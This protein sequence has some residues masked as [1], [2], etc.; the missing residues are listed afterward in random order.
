[1]LVLIL[2]L[3]ATIILHVLYTKMVKS[4]SEY[5]EIQINSLMWLRNS[6][7]ALSILSLFFLSYTTVPAGHVKVATLFGKIQ[8]KPYAEGLHFPVNPLLDWTTFDLRQKT[9]KETAG[10]PSQDKL[11]TD[12][13]VSVQY[14]TIGSK[15]TEILK[16]T[17]QIED[18][19]DVHLIPKLRSILREQGKGVK[20]AQDFFLESV[21][22]QLQISLQEELASYLAPQGLQIDSV[23]IRSVV[24]PHVIRSAIEQ[25]K[26]REQEV[27]K[28]KAELERYATE[29]DQLIKKAES[30][31]KAAKLEAEKIRELADAEAYQ[32]DVINK[33]LAKSQNFIELKKAERWDGKLPIYSGGD[34]VP[35]IDLRK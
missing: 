1:M 7:A 15:T 4:K 34:N 21:Q 5:E 20:Q 2:F 29:Q 8:P 23:L 26:E 6:T 33:Q 31:L 17:G 3:T 13:D 9:H 10:I 18:L 25:T 22:S 16:N 12:V 19:I 27:L 32:I 30:E 35:M 24:L 28:Q 11:I 14:R